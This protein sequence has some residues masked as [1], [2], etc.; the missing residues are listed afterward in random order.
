MLRKL[1]RCIYSLGVVTRWRPP[2]RP[3]RTKDVAATTFYK[4]NSSTQEV[5]K[6]E[7]VGFTLEKI[8]GSGCR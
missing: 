8:C 1:V 6:V 4:Y 2:P 7:S 5:E 3:R